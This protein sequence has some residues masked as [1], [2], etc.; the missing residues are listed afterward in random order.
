M[1]NEA[2]TT[3]VLRM[4]DE[5]SVQ[6]Q[7][8]G[9]TTQ[10]AEIQA[11]QFN[12]ALT[13]MGSAMTAVGSLIGQIE[14]PMAKMASS[15]LLTGGAILTTTSAIIQMI[16]YIKQLITWLR[17][18]AVAKALVTALSGPAGWVNLGLAFAA[19]GVAYAGVT[20]MTG[21]FSS[22][23]TV[24]VQTPAFMGNDSDA[25]KFASTTQRYAR[26]NERIG[27]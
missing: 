1:A 14:N 2:A 3:I 6:M 20:A 25:R 8:F 10:A 16:P 21:G 11:I 7:N 24:N 26:E 22:G 13:A 18:L 23:T 5:A 15:F 27:R 17:N 4:K 19:A 9:Q 12:A